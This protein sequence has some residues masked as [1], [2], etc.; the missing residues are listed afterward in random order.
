MR[1][2][3]SFCILFF[4]LSCHIKNTQSDFIRPIKIVRFMGVDNYSFNINPQ[5]F[6]SQNDEHMFLFMNKAA[7][8]SEIETYKE[9]PES[10]LQEYIYAFITSKK[11]TLYSDYNLKSW[12]LIRNKKREILL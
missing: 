1:K 10:T 7:F 6:W 12:I 4:L 11:D 2:I 8:L 3:I 5:I 9:M